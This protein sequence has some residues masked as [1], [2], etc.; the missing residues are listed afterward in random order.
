MYEI[1][2]AGGIMMVPI[3]LA[4][5][6]AIAIIVDSVEAAATFFNSDRKAAKRI[7][8]VNDPVTVVVLSVVTYLDGLSN[9][10]VYDE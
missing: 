7:V 2:K 10:L 3:I 4:S 5:I 1:V 8:A 9:R 6:I